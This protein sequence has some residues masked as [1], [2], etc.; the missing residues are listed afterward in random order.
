MDRYER[1][2]YKLVESH[3]EL[4]PKEGIVLEAAAGLSPLGEFLMW[5][6]LTVFALDISLLALVHAKQRLEKRGLDLACAVMDLVDRWLP[7]AFF[8]AIF[9]FYFL[10][11]PLLE[12]YHVALKP[13]GFMFCE[14]LLWNE[15]E[16]PNKQHYLL[17]GGLEDKF[18]AWKIY[19]KNETW[20]RGRDFAV[21]PRKILQ[22]IAQKP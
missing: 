11:R 13:G 8:S 18:G 1:G 7:T 21:Q 3:S 17:P 20:K 10:S 2:P 4:L 16:V 5:R 14:I 9:N 6:G 12:R 22:L 19:F 15:G